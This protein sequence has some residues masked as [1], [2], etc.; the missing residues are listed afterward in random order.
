MKNILYTF[1]LLSFLTFSCSEDDN[2]EFSPTSK[3]GFSTTVTA[4]DEIEATDTIEI[5]IVVNPA[6]SGNITISIE[7]DE[8]IYGDDYT[9]LPAASLN[10]LVVPVDADGTASFKFVGGDFTLNKDNEVVFTIIGADGIELGQEAVRIHKLLIE[11]LFVYNEMFNNCDT[12]LPAGWTIFSEA[13]AANWECS[14]DLRGV[15]GVSGDYA[16]EI[17]GFGSDVASSDW[18][19]APAIV[20]PAD[21]NYS[22][23]FA[24]MKRFGGPDLE[25]YYSTDYSGAGDPNAATWTRFT[26]AES[27]LDT[28]EGSFDY[29]QGGQVVLPATGTVYVAFYYTS[30]GVAAGEG[31]V[32]R[33]DNFRVRESSEGAAPILLFSES[34][35]DCVVDTNIS[36]WVTFSVVGDE[37]WLCTSF[38]NNT[39]TG[40]Q[41]NGYNGA[42]LDNEDWLISPAVTLGSASKLIYNYRT[43]FGGPGLE[44]KI[45]TNYSGSGD[46]G[47]A[48]WSDL[49]TLASDN[50]DS[51]TS[52]EITLSA[53]ASQT[54]YIAFVY[55]SN[56]TDGAARWTIDDVAVE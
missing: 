32:Y 1:L 48:T 4:V 27:Q 46:P 51:W 25:I 38:G 43:R 42:P 35:D 50:S 36:D 33:I 56:P 9:T 8:L 2:F 18:L 14:D 30:T 16:M 39:T 7:G 15:S 40:V 22:I 29:K 55:Y 53:Y 52:D 17:S 5:A 24:S 6:K 44:V 45:S 31:A 20:V 47:S 11:K 23:E 37:Q 10:Q 54:V 26:A 34:F 49:K 12:G 41:M 28:N 3:V 13:S 19:I 21:E